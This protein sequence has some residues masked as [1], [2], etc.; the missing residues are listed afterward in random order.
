MSVIPEHSLDILQS[1]ALA[2]VATI[3]ATG[4]PRVSPVW[5]AW[6]GEHVLLSVTK[7]KQRYRNLLREPRVAL[8]IVDPTNPYRSLEIRGKV[9]ELREDLDGSF[10][11]TLSQKY[12]KRARNADEIQPGEERV[13]VVIRPERVVSF[14]SQEQKKEQ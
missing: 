5:F 8:S 13:V 12:L 1:Q 9:I 10:A 6:D 11:Q 3:G 2:H 7:D 4:E 14:P